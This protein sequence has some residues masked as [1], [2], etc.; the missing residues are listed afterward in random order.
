MIILYAQLLDHTDASRRSDQ[1]DDQGLPFLVE[2]LRFLE[3]SIPPDIDKSSG[4]GESTITRAR[5][6]KTGS[7]VPAAPDVA[8]VRESEH[9][10][11]PAERLH[12]PDRGHPMV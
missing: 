6:A 11:A 2:L 12:W 5:A 3:R 1:T 10:Q 8:K 9:S 7:P 4:T